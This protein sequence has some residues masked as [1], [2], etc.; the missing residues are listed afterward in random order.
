MAG[1]P[2]NKVR[3]PLNSQTDKSRVKLA[4]LCLGIAGTLLLLETLL[5]MVYMAGIGFDTL[6]DIL[7]DLCLTM[8]FPIFLIGLSFLRTA[9]IA[10]WI[11]FLAQ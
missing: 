5:G 11:F 10:L 8:A 6:P 7:T 3:N 9:S 1:C 4:K 2:H